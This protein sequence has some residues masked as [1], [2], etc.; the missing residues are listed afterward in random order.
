M[1]WS[2]TAGLEINSFGS[3]SPFGSN[4]EATKKTHQTMHNLQRKFQTP[5]R[6]LETVRGKVGRCA[7]GALMKSGR[8]R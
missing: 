6:F 4:N 5:H 1:K 8:M 2:F 7:S 3:I